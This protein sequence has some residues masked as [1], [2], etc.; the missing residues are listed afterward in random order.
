MSVTGSAGAVDT[1]PGD[2]G[3]DVGAGAAAAAGDATAV[4]AVII[5][6]TTIAPLFL[7][8]NLTSVLLCLRDTA[9]RGRP[10]SRG[11]DAGD[12]RQHP[13]RSMRRLKQR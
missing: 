2:V 4:T 13:C 1:H 12:R 6:A 5:P 8:L 9:A 10:I 7:A 3:G 11:P